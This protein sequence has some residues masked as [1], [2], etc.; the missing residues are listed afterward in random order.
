[1]Y[2]HIY[3]TMIS[4]KRTVILGSGWAGFK[5]L[6][7]INQNAHKVT[8]V[9]PRN[10]F[11]FTPLLASTAVGTLEFRCIT[12][13]LRQH[14]KNLEFYE[15]LATKIDFKQKR[16]S[17]ESKLMKGQKEFTL[18]YDK[19]IIA[20]GAISNTFNIPG[21]REHAFF[22]KDISDS[23]RI[24]TRIIEN[25]ER[26]K[27]PGVSV[28][29]QRELLHF[30]SVGGGPTGVECCAEIYDF[31]TEGLFILTKDLFKLYP[32]LKDLVQMTLVDVAPKILTSFDSELSEYAAKRFQREGINIRT[33]TMVE[34]V[35]K[36]GL[37]LRNADPI[38]SRCIIWATG[39]APNPLLK[40]LELEL[41]PGKRLITDPW[42]RVL[43]K[44]GTPM[45]DVFA[46]GDCATIK[47]TPLPQTA[48]VATQKAVYLAKSFNQM[49][50]GNDITSNPQFSFK[51][52]GSLAYLGGWTAI[53]DT[54]G[55]IKGRGFF[56]WVFWR[57][58]NYLDNVGIY[59]HECFNE[60]QNVDTH[61]LVSCL[62]IRTR[63]H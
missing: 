15:A 24:R 62:G 44:T 4:K 54:P 46:M 27:Q 2:L 30:C 63:Y 9:S 52:L 17:V 3:P 19:L 58:V 21:V 20:C 36:E 6:D 55:K 41:D 48:Q 13:P 18:D 5:F 35:R 12:E 43:D 1:M 38:K 10:Y 26:A 61:V 7:K 47:D 22:L 49:A 56:A 33:G 28:E 14:S 59:D 37:I 34:E 50:D 31:I 53:A 57:S 45:T 8:L 32:D 25:F 60:K 42:L 40:S 39:L 16:I 23:K 11:V 51:N 29:D